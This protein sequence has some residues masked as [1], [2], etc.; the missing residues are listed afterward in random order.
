MKIKKSKN[1]RHAQGPRG[2]PAPRFHKHF[3]NRL[4]NIVRFD[5]QFFNFFFAQKHHL[6]Y[7]KSWRIWRVTSGSPLFQIPEPTMRRSAP[8]S[9]IVCAFSRLTPMSTDIT[10]PGK[11]FLRNFIFSSA[12]SVKTTPAPW[13]PT[14]SE[15]IQCKKSTL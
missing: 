4:A 8:E 7:T 11:L 2:M 6:D 3:N 1:I 9:R 12:L 5:F 13:K 10:T 15:P 14:W